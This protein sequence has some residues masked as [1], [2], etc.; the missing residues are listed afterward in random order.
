MKTHFTYR[1]F[2]NKGN[3]EIIGEA[4]EQDPDKR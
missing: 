1:I 2:V 4:H 3:I